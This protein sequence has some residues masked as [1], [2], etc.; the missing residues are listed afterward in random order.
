MEITEIILRTLNKPESLKQYVPD[1]LQHDKRYLLDSTKIRT[2]LGWTPKISFEEGL[3]ETIHW[4]QN[5]SEWWQRCKSGAYQDYY[6]HYY[7]QKIGML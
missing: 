6:K 1:R 3:R 7:Q 2:E 4:Y 5:N